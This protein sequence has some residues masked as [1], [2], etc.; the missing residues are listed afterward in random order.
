VGNFETDFSNGY[1]FG[2]ILA[3]FNQVDLSQFTKKKNKEAKVNNFYLIE[4]ALRKLKVRFDGK[5]VHQIMEEERGAS[6]RLL[7]QIKLAS[8]KLNAEAEEPLSMSNLPKDKMHTI[9]KNKLDATLEMSK[10][11]PPPT[12]GGKDIRTAKQKRADGRTIQFDVA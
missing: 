6:L 7:Y 11:I 4:T 12:V 10:S 9:L 2:E 3:G 1:L 5:L 8:Q